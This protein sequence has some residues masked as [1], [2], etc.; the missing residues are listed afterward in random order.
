MSDTRRSLK[1]GAGNG[2]WAGWLLAAMVALASCGNGSGQAGSSGADGGGPA[3]SAA[4]S[5]SSSGSGSGGG[6]AITGS[7]GGAGGASSSSGAASSGGTSSDDGATSGASSGSDGSSDTG[8]SCPPCGP[9]VG[10]SKNPLRALVSST[11]DP[12]YIVLDTTS[13][14]FIS[15]GNFTNDGA[16]VKVPLAGGT[17]AIL[18]TN[19]QQPVGLAVDSTR[20]YWGTQVDSA[21]HSAALDGSHA[22]VLASQSGWFPLEIAIDAAYVYWS[23]TGPSSGQASIMRVPK[24]GGTPTI[25]EPNL[26]SDAIAVDASSIYWLN[27]PS[28]VSSTWAN[29]LTKAPSSGGSPT[30][31]ASVDLY[32]A[33]SGSSSYLDVLVL[34][35]S[36]LY[37]PDRSLGLMRL[38]G[39]AG[40]AT[41]VSA[42]TPITFAVDATNVYGLFDCSIFIGGAS[43]GGFSVANSWLAVVPRTGGSWTTLVANIGALSGEPSIAVDASNVYWT[44]NASIVSIAK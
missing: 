27:A 5:T 38:A 12:Q 2:Q 6:N 22:S 10:T 1:G 23:W 35:G 39:G 7:G 37:F 36:D 41:V 8:S 43:G 11:V 19:Q 13:V 31:L 16:V 26:F 3:T 15:R 28:S 33:S 44:D 25:L 4:T 42:G 30:M 17:P 34:Y 29:T 21:V 18:A 14:Y 9:C 40:N 24:G 20:I 32:S